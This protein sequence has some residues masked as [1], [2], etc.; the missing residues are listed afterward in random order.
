MIA[1]TILGTIPIFYSPEILSA[2]T[3]SGTMV[4]GLAPVFIFW[5]AKMPKF[6]FY[7]PVAVGLIMGLIIAF[8]KVP[9]SMLFTDGKYADL[10]VVNL[11]GTLLSFVL[12]FLPI[13]NRLWAKY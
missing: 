3:I 7:A 2:T 12:F 10:L 1:L 8:E 11:W 4:I 6:S 13:T 9:Q 5:N